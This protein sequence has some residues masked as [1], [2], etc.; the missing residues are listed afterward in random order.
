MISRYQW[1]GTVSAPSSAR[2]GL[3]SSNARAPHLAPRPLAHASHPLALLRSDS[4][5][6]TTPHFSIGPGRMQ[7]DEVQWLAAC[8]AVARAPLAEKQQQHN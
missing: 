6:R 5:A 3:S 4:I 8:R 2:D 1:V 7:A